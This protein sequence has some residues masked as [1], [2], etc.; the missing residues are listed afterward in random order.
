MAKANS[1]RTI[2]SNSNQA[3]VA[4]PRPYKAGHDILTLRAQLRAAFAL[5]QLHDD[6]STD[7]C[8]L[9]VGLSLIHA[10]DELTRIWEILDAGG[11]A[12]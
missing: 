2:P 4:S 6:Y 1:T 7:E 12:A 3:A 11:N 5:L 9:D 8:L 10:D